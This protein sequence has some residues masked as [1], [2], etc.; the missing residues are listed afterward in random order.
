M[1]FD[2]VSLRRAFVGWANCRHNLTTSIRDLSR[3]SR[4]PSKL[5]A[6]CVGRMSSFGVEGIQGDAACN[7]R[8]AG[9]RFANGGTLYYLQYPHT[10]EEV[11]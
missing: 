11:D 1:G 2:T 9:R 7:W 5:T 4:R 8:A 6:I 3:R 10:Q